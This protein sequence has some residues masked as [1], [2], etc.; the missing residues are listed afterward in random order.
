MIETIIY[1]QPL[2]EVIRVALRLEQLFK[3]I[4]Y[5]MQDHTEIGIRQTIHYI[6][7]ILHVLDRPDLKAK[8]AKELS[9]QKAH[10]ARLGNTPSV[11]TEKLS[12]LIQRLDNLSHSLIA[13]SGK[14]GHRLREVELINHLRLH[15]AT[16][17]S[18][19]S[20]D[21]PLYHYWLQQPY[22]VH[23]QAIRLWL[24]EFNEIR[25]ATELVLNLIRHNAR[26]EEKTAVHG[27]YQE[28][29]DPQ[30]NLRMISIEID[31]SIPAFPEISVGRHFFSVRFFT[32]DIIKRPSQY[33]SNMVF[34]VSYGQF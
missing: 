3:Q 16:P 22:E 28:L 4:E 6:I 7:D 23:Q 8:L 19:C 24:S 33:T 15:L 34:F 26:R 12:T 17:G 20:F 13:N 18:D 21:L 2:N 25:E 27:F 32:P 10:L 14:L 11:N 30:S 5:Q 1:D 9:Y 31:K 29:M